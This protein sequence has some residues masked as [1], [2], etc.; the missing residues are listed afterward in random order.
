MNRPKTDKLL[1]GAALTLSAGLSLAWLGGWLSTAASW[2][3]ARP[4]WPSGWRLPAGSARVAAG[5]R[6]RNDRSVA[7]GTSR[8]SAGSIRAPRPGRSGQREPS[9]AAAREALG[10]TLAERI[11]ETVLRLARRVQEL[12]QSR[13]SL[14][15]RC[16]RATQQA[17]QIRQ[18]LSGLADP[19]LAID[20]YDEIV[21]A[22]RSAEELF[23]LDGE[24]AETKAL[25]QLV[26][27]QRLVQLLTSTRQRKTAVASHRR[28]RDRR[29]RRAVALVSGDGRQVGGRRP[30][31]AG[32]RPWPRAPWPCSATSATRRRCRSGT[33]SSS[34][35]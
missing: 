1:A 14:E 27:C 17:E 29:R 15:V 10:P 33:P 28:N 30:T 12:E 7:N 13:T 20:D 18:I 2:P 31:T 4:C 9:A 3:C 34:P 24:K 26:H 11:R 16:R 21:L 23:H 8:P 5:T 35:R 6:P 19:I 22:N 25:E 32:R